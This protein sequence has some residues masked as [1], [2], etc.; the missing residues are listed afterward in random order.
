[1][2][3][4]PPG[5]PSPLPASRQPR[6]GA[7]DF[8]AGLPGTF[9]PT[10]GPLPR[11]DWNPGERGAAMGPALGTPRI[12]VGVDESPASLAALRWAAREAGLR[13]VR[14]QVVRAWERARWRVA[15]YASRPHHLAGRDEDRAA[16]SAR[17]EGAVRTTLGP[18]PA[19]PV[20]VEVAEGLAT[21]VLLDRAA[22]AELLVLGGV[23]STGRDAIGPV[24]RD[25]LRH[26]PCPIVV[27][28]WER[29]EIPVPV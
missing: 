19:V 27:V 12:V 28:S 23:A 10:A 17:L 18:A 16:A 9:F 21:Q 15:P 20:T 8:G 4:D 7:A 24:A 14:L 13:A 22:G 26:P 6:Q 5:T 11:P 25:C 2:T 1:V 3:A 29:N